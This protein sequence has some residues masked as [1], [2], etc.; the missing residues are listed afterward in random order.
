MEVSALEMHLHCLTDACFAVFRG[1][2]GGPPVVSHRSSLLRTAELFTT[3]YTEAAPNKIM[4]RKH[5]G[6]GRGTLHACFVV[7]HQPNQRLQVLDPSPALAMP[8]VELWLCAHDLPE[9]MGMLPGSEPIFFGLSRK[10]AETGFS[11]HP[12]VSRLV[13]RPSAKK[14]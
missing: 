9:G 11:I 13:T 3:T 8:G 4:K 5:H 14:I 12:M 10:D 7:A 2:T 1:G 6:S